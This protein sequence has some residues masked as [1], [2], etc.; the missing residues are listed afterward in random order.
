MRFN[1]ILKSTDDG[2]AKLKCNVYGQNE[3]AKK[4][5]YFKVFSLRANN[6]DTNAK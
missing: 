5:E 4:K 1:I 2:L 3:L 6:Y